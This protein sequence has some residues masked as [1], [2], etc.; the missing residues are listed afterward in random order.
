[1][2]GAASDDP[3]ILIGQGDAPV[4]LGLQFANRHGLIAGAT[5]TGKTVTLQVLAEGFSA[6]G[7]PV[8]CADIKGD[9]AGI[10]QA[11]T[12]N[13]KLE[14]RAVSLGVA[15]FAYRASPAVFW[16]VFGQQGHPVRATVAEMGPMLLGRML[17]LNDTQEGVLSIAFKLADDEGLLLLDY[18]DLRAVLAHVASRADVLA[19]TY[20]NVSKA[21]VGTIQRKLLTLEQAGGEP[22]FGEP[23]LD[24][25]D[26]LLVTPDGRGAVNVLAADKLVASPRLYATFMLWLLSAL[27]EELPEVGDLDRPKLVFFFD[28]AHLLFRDAPKPLVAKIEQ[29]VR[30]IRSKG[31]GV[32]LVTQNPV[33]VPPGV[34][35]QL[36]NRVQ[37]ALRAF[38]PVEQKSVRAAAETFRPNP[39]FKTE[40]VITELAVGEALVSTL[41]PG[42]MP[43]AVERTR[44]CPPRGRIGVVTAEERA[45]IIGQSPIGTKYDTP[46]DRESAYERLQGRV[47]TVADEAPRAPWGAPGGAPQQREDDPWG[48]RA[49]PASAPTPTS[50]P[51]WMPPAPRYPASPMTGA[52]GGILGGLFGSQGGRQG[53]GE[54]MVKSIARSLGSQVGTQVGRAV[55]RG[56]LGSILKR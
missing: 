33:D 54:A 29:V 3:S 6:K 47:T 4:R 5:G 19:T 31:V 32:Y 51:S 53:V 38:T 44:I 15:D 12:P 50:E 48:L 27:F 37:H 20:G 36:G 28:E 30:L 16:D 8:F 26:L 18:K 14:Q 9:L 7:V 56:V 39:R 1:M 11:G 22:F 23:A 10:S 24:L 34:L 25:G 45:T 2:S 21:S 13:P 40:A 41:G 52:G 35:G 17:E 46:V 43:G 55:L 42:G 49:R